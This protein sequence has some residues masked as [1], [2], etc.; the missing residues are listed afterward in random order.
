MASPA[1]KLQVSGISLLGVI[2][3]PRSSGGRVKLIDVQ[4]WS[5]PVRFLTV[6]ASVVAGT[7]DPPLTTFG[8]VTV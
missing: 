5:R 7:S 2:V 1:P 4:S 6:K 3:P 8:G